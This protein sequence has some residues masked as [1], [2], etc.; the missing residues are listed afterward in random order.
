M[1]GFSPAFCRP[2]AGVR[3]VR[4]DKKC[5]GLEAKATFATLFSGF[6][7]AQG[8]RLPPGRLEPSSPG[9]TSGTPAGHWTSPFLQPEAVVH[10]Q[11]LLP[12][13]QYSST[14]ST[15]PIKNTSGRL[16]TCGE[17]P[18]ALKPRSPAREWNTVPAGPALVAQMSRPE[19]Y[20][21]GNP[22]AQFVGK[23]G[24]RHRASSQAE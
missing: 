9:R 13:K 7:T 21:Q 18:A 20:Q 5:F 17:T 12:R 4:S 1:E 14:E 11:L 2:S 3:G 15:L 24:S 23:E 8:P 16:C 6:Q 10:L 22:E 19:N